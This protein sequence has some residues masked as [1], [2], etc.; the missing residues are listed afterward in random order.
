M[1]LLN[2]ERKTEINFINSSILAILQM[3]KTS[4]FDFWRIE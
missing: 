4:P 3:K 1:H 2:D